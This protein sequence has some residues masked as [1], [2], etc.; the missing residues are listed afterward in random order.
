MEVPLIKERTDE[1][2][3]N[4]EKCVDYEKPSCSQS[5]QKVK[6]KE[7]IEMMKANNGSNNIGYAKDWHFQQCVN[8]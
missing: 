8:K 4:Y 3:E 5:C 2:L 1:V 6:L 7:Y